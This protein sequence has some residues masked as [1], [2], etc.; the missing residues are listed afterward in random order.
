ASMA[1]KRLDRLLD[2]LKRSVLFAKDF[3][4]RKRFSHREWAGLTEEECGR[5]YEPGLAAIDRAKDFE[6][7]AEIVDE[8][9]QAKHA[10][11]VP[12]LAELWADC[13]LEPVRTAAGHAL[14]EI[15]TAE[16]RRALVGFI[17]DSDHLSVFLAVAAVFDEDSAKAFDRFSPYFEAGRVTRPGGT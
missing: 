5:S 7:L 16:A 1:H 13:A 11:A 15:G 9:G 17:E 14:R 4:R 6:E 3:P 2:K 8:L 12:L 10:A